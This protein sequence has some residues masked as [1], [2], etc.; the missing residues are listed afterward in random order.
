MH[1]TLPPPCSFCLFEVFRPTQDFFTSFGDVTIAGEGLHFFKLC[2]APIAINQSHTYWDTGHPFT[3]AI[4]KR[5]VTLATIAERLAEEL[6]LPVLVTWVCPGWDSNTQ[7]SARGAHALIQCTLAA[8]Y[9]LKTH[10]ICK[11]LNFVES[12]GRKVIIIV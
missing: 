6:S 4:P 8:V 1:S 12:K 11:Y 10:F 3:M 5:P 2:S 9:L 7:P